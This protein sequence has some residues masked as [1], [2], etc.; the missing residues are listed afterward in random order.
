LSFFNELK[1]R[2]VFKVGIGYVLIAWLIAQVLQL[3]FESFGTPDW[4]I[5]TALVLLA[6]G[7]PFALFLAWAYELTPEGLKRENEVDRSQPITPQTIKKLKGAKT[8]A[9]KLNSMIYKSRCKGVVNWDLVNSIL[10]SSTENNPE[11][12]ITGVLLATETHFL[13][14]LEGEF[15]NL[16]ATF[17]RISR[18]TRH[19]N[20]QLISF[21]EIDER[22][23]GDWVMHGIGLFDLNRDLATLLR[24]KFGEDNGSIRLPCTPSE[25]M[26][27][28]SILMP[29]LELDEAHK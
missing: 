3:V 7:F 26:E 27:L 8:P 23:F 11:N 14:V 25:V 18:D 21:T 29:E 10:S 28:L 19:D 6:A 4:A 24:R 5:K 12:G 9:K 1:R 22:K 20:V 16:N 2:N 15:E 13:Q 17:E